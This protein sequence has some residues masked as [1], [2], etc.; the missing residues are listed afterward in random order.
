MP[1]QTHFDAGVFEAPVTYFLM[2]ILMHNANPAMTVTELATRVEKAVANNTDQVP[3]SGVLQGAGD[4][5]GEFIFLT[6]NAGGGVPVSDVG[7][8]AALT[9]NP[10][11]RRTIIL[12]PMI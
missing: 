3:E 4:E 10:E 7:S 5:P 12:F 11:F 2:Q 8:V 9:H 1:C 6:S